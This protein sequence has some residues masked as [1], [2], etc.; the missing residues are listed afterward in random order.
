MIV[1]CLCNF[2]PVPLGFRSCLCCC[3]CF[4]S[5]FTNEN[6]ENASKCASIPS[7]C[8]GKRYQ[9]MGCAAQ[10]CLN[11][12]LTE[13]Y[14]ENRFRYL[15]PEHQFLSLSFGHIDSANTNKCSTIDGPMST[16]KLEIFQLDTFN[17]LS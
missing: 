12:D 8:L 16:L 2:F 3:C 11:I 13:H 10:R 4:C 7:K 9:I 1:H 5:R 14:L 6:G 15:P 17:S